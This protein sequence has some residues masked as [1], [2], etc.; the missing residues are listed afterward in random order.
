MKNRVLSVLP[1]V[2]LILSVGL[3]SCGGEQLPEITDYSLAISSS[4]GGEVTNP[5]EGAFIHDEGEVVSLVAEAD[6]GYRFVNWTGDTDEI[7]AVNSSSTAI[8]IHGDY[9]ITANFERISLVSW[10]WI[11][12]FVVAVVLAGLLIFFVQGKRP[13]WLKGRR[14]AG[15]AQRR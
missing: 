7:A 11:G 12:T 2:M 14:R 8:T 4:E 1:A 6:G 10:P 5:D 15:R 13:T 3:I 9:A